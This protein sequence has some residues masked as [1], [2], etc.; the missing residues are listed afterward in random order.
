MNE[1]FLHEHWR[2][3]FDGLRCNQQDNGDTLAYENE[4]LSHVCLNGSYAYLNDTEW[5]HRC[6]PNYWKNVGWRRAA[7]VW[8]MFNFFVGLLGNLFTLV[9]VLYAKW[10]HR[11]ILLLKK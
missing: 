6:Y 1:S 7:G 5:N 3:N 4:L 9:A 11:Y 8:S 2:N 10:K